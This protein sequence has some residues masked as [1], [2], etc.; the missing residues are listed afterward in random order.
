MPLGVAQPEPITNKDGITIVIR[1]FMPLGVA[2][3]NLSLKDLM[4]LL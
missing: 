3:F 1:A 4:L 2:Q